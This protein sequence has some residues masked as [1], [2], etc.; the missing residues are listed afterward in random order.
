MTERNNDAID[1][2]YS[3]VIKNL[4]AGTGDKAV[5]FFDLTFSGDRSV[6]C[7][8]PVSILDRARARGV[9]L[10]GRVDA[11]GYIKAI[12]V[13]SD[14]KEISS[15]NG[16]FFRFN[17]VDGENRVVSVKADGKVVAQ[18]SKMLEAPLA[19]GARVTLKG[20]TIKSTY[21]KDGREKVA[22][23]FNAR[24]GFPASDTEANGRLFTVLSIQRPKTKSEISALAA[25]KAARA[26]TAPVATPAAAVNAN[27]LTAEQQKYLD[28]DIPF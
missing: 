11:G 28:A 2:N 13:V 14:L 5:A 19:N 22:Y 16:S 4:T 12:G 6:P 15:S 7:V 17:L 25:A 23:T 20:R 10:A 3:G 9:D 26:E 27:G 21:S 1:T 24:V 8:A 18:I